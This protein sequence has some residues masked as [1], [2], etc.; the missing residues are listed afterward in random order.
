MKILILGSGGR[1]CTFAWKL[2]QELGRENIFTAPGNAGTELYGSNVDLD[3]NDFDAVGNFCIQ[4]N[5][6]CILPGGEDTLVAG[7]K[8]HI[9]G[10]EQF[11][12][13]FVFG[14]DKEASKLEG[15]KE[16]AKQFMLKN[17][18]P[19]AAYRSFGVSGI[20]EAKDFLGTLS[21]PY[22]IKADGLAA[23]KG[24]VISRT[25]PEA[26][27]C[28]DEMLGEEKFGKAS[29]TIVI[30]EFLKGIEVSFF[31]ATDGKDYLLL[32]E[33]KDYKRIGE[34]D[35][36]LNT[37]GMGAV[38]PVSF[39]D[40]VFI[41]KVKER[42]IEPTMKGIKKDHLNYQG[43]IFFGLISVAGDPYV[44]EYNCRMGDPETEVV[45]PRMETRLSDIILKAKEGKIKEVN[46]KM[47][48]SSCCT[49]MLVS[50]GYPEKYEKNKF[51]RLPVN[52]ESLMF[53]SGTK[54]VDSDIFTNGGRV[55]AVTSLAEDAA[56]CLKM[57][58]ET[59]KEIDFEGKY[60]RTDIGKDLLSLEKN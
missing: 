60:F 6:G 12:H 45:I 36:G 30:E 4:N 47:D 59:I 29:Q 55:L 5:I 46:L 26:N 8:D 7:I 2:A 32:P 34:N 25:L 9:A 33:A 11:K 24:V 44:I 15:S 42:I 23:G 39:A 27:K 50:G 41:S 48:P 38:S 51:I 10:S 54:R 57:C 58:Y 21:P 18:I 22:V 35:T 37:G 52:T 17:N 49:V 3:I 19:T 31:I 56:D 1:E 16:Y 28:I 53:H 14:P 40:E 20:N 43:F 13:L